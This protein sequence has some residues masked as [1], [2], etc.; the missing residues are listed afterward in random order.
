[1]SHHETF[2]ERVDDP[3]R[4]RDAVRRFDDLNAADPHLESFG[5][6][7]RPRELLN[8]ERLCDW[9]MV[10]APD[11]SEVLR[12]AARS[13]HLCRW[14]IPRNS[15]DMTRAGYHQWRTSLRRFHAEKSAEVLRAAGYNEEFV[16]K[17][18]D[19]NLKKNFP[20]DPESCVLED[21]LCLVF[22]QF[23]L[24]DLA[25]RTEEAKVINALQKSWKKMTPTAREHALGLSYGPRELSLLERALSQT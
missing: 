16:A 17:V 21:A 24:A 4:F 6:L 20:A 8:A 9:V 3:A 18:R 5:G 19:L 11:A 12:L 10:L 25:A 7:A 2:F 22:L 23:Q 1:M 14:K 13:Q 15:F